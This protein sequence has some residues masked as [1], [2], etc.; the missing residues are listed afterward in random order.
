MLFEGAEGALEPRV[1]V[2]DVE[3]SRIRRDA[4]EKEREKRNQRDDGEIGD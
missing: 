2:L 4:D 3:H 1:T